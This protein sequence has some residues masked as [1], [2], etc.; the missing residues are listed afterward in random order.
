MTAI[1]GN[2]DKPFLDNGR[3]MKCSECENAYHLAERYGFSEPHS[4]LKA[5]RAADSGGAQRSAHR[6]RKVTTRVRICHYIDSPVRKG[7]PWR[8]MAQTGLMGRSEVLDA[9]RARIEMVPE[10]CSCLY[11]SFF[12]SAIHWVPFLLIVSLI[13]PNASFLQL[14]KISSLVY[15]WP[16]AASAASTNGS[17]STIILI[18]V[19][20]AQPDACATT[21]WMAPFHLLDQPIPSS[22]SAHPA[23]LNVSPSSAPFSGQER[24]AAMGP[25]VNFFCFIVQVGNRPSLYS[26]RSSDTCLLLFPGPSVIYDNVSE[27]FHVLKLLLCGDIES[28]PGPDDKVLTAIASLSA[29]V[30]WRHAELLAV[31][32]QVQTNQ[33]LLEQ[34]VTD[35]SSRLATVETMVESYDSGHHIPDLPQAVNTVIRN[36]TT[37]LH[38]RLDEL[39]DRSR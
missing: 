7:P 24:A 14:K 15:T 5:K 10:L 4:K 26:K 32:N 36:E 20:A 28:N 18:A 31:L 12:T 37:A 3:V 19:P 34:K 21:A 9:R 33:S 8:P 22:T 29:K 11:I 38:S 25:V 23:D 2:C 16:C 17:T 35:L 39:E 27:C 30:D 1:C 6:N 13:K